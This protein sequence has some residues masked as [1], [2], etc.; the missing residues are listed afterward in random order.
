MEGFLASYIYLTLL[1]YWVIGSEFFSWYGLR[2][3]AQWTVFEPHPSRWPIYFM[4]PCLRY[5]Y[6]RSHWC[7][8]IIA[9]HYAISSPPLSSSKPSGSHPPRSGLGYF[10]IPSSKYLHTNFRSYHEWRRWWR[11]IK[12]PIPDQLLED[13]LMKSLFPPI[14]RDVS[15]G[16]TVSEEQ[17]ISCA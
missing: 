3:E 10:D 16:G 8:F 5:S 7:V 14:T 2:G 15:M 13:W 17:A 1:S 6:P 12:D 4:F 11:P 9:I